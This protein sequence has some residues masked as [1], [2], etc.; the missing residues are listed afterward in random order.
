MARVLALV[1]D[2][3]FGSNVQG[4]L[5]AAGHEVVLRGD[6]GGLRERL[7]EADLLLVDLTRPEL[8]GSAL[9]GELREAGSLEGVPTLGFYAHVDPDTRRRALAAGFDMVVPRSRMAR[10]GATLVAELLGE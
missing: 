5:S 10:E 9:V 8:D 2:L 1:P 6:A 4:T 7:A 3:L